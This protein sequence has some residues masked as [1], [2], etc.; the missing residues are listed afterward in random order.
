MT[1]LTRKHR[2]TLRRVFRPQRRKAPGIAYRELV[3]LLRAL[4]AEIDESRSGSR[5]WVSLN[6][7]EGVFHRPHGRRPVDGGLD[8]L[9][10]GVAAP[11]R[12]RAGVRSRGG[13]ARGRVASLPL[14]PMPEADRMT[15]GTYEAEIEYQAETDEF[16]GHV[17]NVEPDMILFRGRS[18]D[19]L[20]EDF[21]G[22]VEFYEQKK[23]QARR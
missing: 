23:R 16:L 1:D 3:S 19:E 8:G 17:V 21:A 22:Q 13:G 5:V 6:G 18:I 10:P 4:G 20:R 2:E 7:V 15:H 12:R 11:G 9:R 14:S